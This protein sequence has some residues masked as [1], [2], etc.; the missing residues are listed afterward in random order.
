MTYYF[1]TIV[2]LILSVP[3]YEILANQI[4]CQKFALKNEGQGHKG[5]N[6]DL[7]HSTANVCT[8]IDFLRILANI[9]SG[10]TGLKIIKSQV[11]ILLQNVSRS[12][13]SKDLL[14]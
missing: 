14:F 7:H 8:Y 1:M 13:R 4:K 2:L 10:A 12:I 5:E 9:E 6:R 3:I 11:V